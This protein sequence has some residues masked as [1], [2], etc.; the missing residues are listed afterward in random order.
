MI[1]PKDHNFE[2]LTT[3]GT[4]YTNNADVFLIAQETAT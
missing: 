1:I 3:S 2:V 4:V